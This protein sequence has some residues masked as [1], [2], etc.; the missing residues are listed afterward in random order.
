MAIRI[1]ATSAFAL[2]AALVVAQPARA[3]FFS[4]FQM[5]PSQ[6]AGMLN[7]DGYRLRGPMIRRGDV[8]LCDVVSVTGRPARL[9][10]D[11]RDGHVLERFAASPH[12]RHFGD[13]PGAL[14][15]PR[16]VGD[17]DPSRSAGD[18]ASTGPKT[19]MG[20]DFN[21]PSRAYGS[22][23]LFNWKSTP[24]PTSEATTH[25][26]PKHHASRKRKDTAV[27]KESPAPADSTGAKPADASA[28]VAAVAP[29]A[30]AAP[31][32]AAPKSATPTPAPEREQAKADAPAAAAPAP[33]PEAPRKKLNDL[34]VGTLD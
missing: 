18:D 22:D 17:D 4:F 1:A 32:E 16:D 11:A 5:S 2:A 26:K 24:A 30:P 25:P 20:G 13:P 14:R 12:R 29:S 7:D 28:S 3:Q 6:I 8:Y 23:A 21:S 31:S 34:P 10:V 15:P 33:K 19:A 27:A 9:I